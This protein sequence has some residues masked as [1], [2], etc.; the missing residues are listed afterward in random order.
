[1]SQ[2][3]AGRPD[4]VLGHQQPA[5][6]AALNLVGDVAGDALFGLNRGGAG[7]AQGQVQQGRALGQAIAEDRGR[8]ARG[9]A[10]D[11]LSTALPSDMMVTMEMQALPGK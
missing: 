9:A 5:R 10:G 3:E 8:Q 6:Q 11:L 7:V 4:P 2:R 1:M